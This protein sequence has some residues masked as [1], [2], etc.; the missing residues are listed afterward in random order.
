ME[1]TLNNINFQQLHSHRKYSPS[2]VAWED[3]VIYFLLLD[4]FSDG[5]ESGYRDLI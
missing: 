5:N 1:K 2:P 4:R 3:Q